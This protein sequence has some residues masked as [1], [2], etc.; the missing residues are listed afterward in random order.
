MKTKVSGSAFLWDL[1][2][3]IPEQWNLFSLSG[4]FSSKID[5]GETGKTGCKAGAML[6]TKL[7]VIACSFIV[8]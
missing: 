3:E 8:I 6:G 5:L 2:R 7:R 1:G 4:Q